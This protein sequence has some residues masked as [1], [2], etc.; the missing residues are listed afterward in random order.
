MTVRVLLCWLGLACGPAEVE[1]PVQRQPAKTQAAPDK[2]HTKAP[3]PLPV[4]RD[5][6]R[7]EHALVM[8]VAADGAAGP[9]V[10]EAA[11]AELRRMRGP[12]DAFPLTHGLQ[13]HLAALRSDP[14]G[15][16][17]A[18]ARLPLDRRVG[19]RRFL[20]DDPDR[21]AALLAAHVAQY[22]DEA[23][24]TLPP[25]QR[26]LG[27]P[28]PVEPPPLYAAFEQWAGASHN[29]GR[30]ASWSTRAKGPSREEFIAELR[31]GEGDRVADV[32]AGEG[33]FLGPIAS[34]VGPSG[35]YTGV[36]IDAG[37]VE[38]LSW[39]GATLGWSQVD[40]A[41]SPLERPVLDQ[42][43]YDVVVV[44]EVMKAVVTNASART[45]EGR[46][47]A[48]HW[49]GGLVDALKPDGRLVVVD[50]DFGDAP[51]GPSLDLLAELAAEAGLP[52][53]RELDGYGRM[54]HVLE[55][56]R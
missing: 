44:C 41:L 12:L 16:E 52:T 2:E 22:C 49:L 17:A 13:A 1:P 42:A 6:F 32:G 47:A 14:A 55:F 8:A 50:H 3:G 45:P 56:S 4:T 43:D 19:A 33:Y 29:L 27:C 51:N 37:L 54:N 25:E 36:E 7:V 24:T 40:A 18:L 30:V 39:T 31:I 28:A 11:L 53:A 38:H 21:G 10:Q 34:A 15:V 5:H 20:V 46:A 35:R 9:D 26:A 48:L 23:L